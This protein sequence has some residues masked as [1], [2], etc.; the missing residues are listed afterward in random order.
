MDAKPNS[1][2]YVNNL[3]EKV[4]KE[5]LK[6]SLYHLFS[7]FGSILDIVALKTIKMR[8]QAF[9]VF[10]D[11]SNATAAL[12]SLQGCP[13]YNKPMRLDFA[14]S[15]SEA[16]QKMKGTFRL[17]KKEEDGKDGAKKKKEKKVGDAAKN[18]IDH[19]S[20]FAEVDPNADADAA[21]NQLLFIT[22]LP[23]E[24]NLE[25]IAS[26]FGQHPGYKEVRLV[27]GRSDI[28]FV[29]YESE[30]TAASARDSLN[31]FKITPS[32]PLNITFAKH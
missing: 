12:R 5:E 16:I 15:E 10:K 30:L 20:S 7:Q 4:K 27:P 29:E 21:P 25:A 28:A 17:K 2:L 22:N 32:N 6:K 23:A 31:G 8:G 18:G 14:Q 11:I 24:A 9:I 26:I 13:F 1:T 3:N 19:F